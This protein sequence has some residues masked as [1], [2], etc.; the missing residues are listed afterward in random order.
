MEEKLD[1]TPEQVIVEESNDTDA[2]MP[3]A[4]LQNMQDLVN[5]MDEAQKTHSDNS[6]NVI[7][8]K[9]FAAD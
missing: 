4:V 7:G 1:D 5:M 3:L 2:E 8:S 6:D 9:A